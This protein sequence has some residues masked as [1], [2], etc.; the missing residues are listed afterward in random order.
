MHV[1]THIHIHTHTG[2][3]PALARLVTGVPTPEREKG[4]KRG[5]Q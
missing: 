3:T 4:R 2:K 1:S 5:G